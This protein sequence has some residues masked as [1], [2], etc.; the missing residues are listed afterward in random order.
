VGC[1]KFPGAMG[2]RG[3]GTTLQSVPGQ[4]P[5]MVWKYSLKSSATSDI[6]HLKREQET[7]LSI[8]ALKHLASQA[9]LTP[10]SLIKV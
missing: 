3:T 6:L 7:F 1:D 2:G 4:N 5:S 9:T 10:E 8:Q